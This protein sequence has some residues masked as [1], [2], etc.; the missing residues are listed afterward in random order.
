[1]GLERK[2]GKAGVN[3]SLMSRK[4]AIRKMH[5][6]QNEFRR[7]CI[8]KGIYPADPKNNTW[9]KNKVAQGKVY[10]RKEDIQF[11]S[12]EPIIWKFWEL[13][14][15]LKRLAKL[16]ARKDI[17]TLESVRENRPFYQLGHIVKERY[18]TFVEAI[19]DLDDCLS[20][21]F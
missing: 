18:P 21:L 12:H 14:I 5:L 4:R 3:H 6:T 1:M 7:L 15:F 10:Y 17:S 11:L 16:K 20:M 2:R 9:I 19:R 13:K 8:L